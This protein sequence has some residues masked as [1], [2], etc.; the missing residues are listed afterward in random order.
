MRKKIFVTVAAVLLLAAAG[1]LFWLRPWEQGEEENAMEFTALL[2]DQVT[3]FDGTSGKELELSRANQ[4]HAQIDRV[5]EAFNAGK[6]VP[7]REAEEAVGI[8]V[9]VHFYDGDGRDLFWFQTHGPG[10]IVSEGT[11]YQSKGTPL[12]EDWLLS[13]LG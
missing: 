3:I 9:L 11:V 13:L 5:V 10:E 2:V 7:E 4:D 8:S 6:Y 1:V 12:E